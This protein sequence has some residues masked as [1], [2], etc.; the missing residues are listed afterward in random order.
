MLCDACVMMCHAWFLLRSLYDESRHMLLVCNSFFD[1]VAVWCDHINHKACICLL[2]QLSGYAVCLF[3]FVVVLCFSSLFCL[4]DSLHCCCLD[5]I[6]YFFLHPCVFLYTWPPG[7]CIWCVHVFICCFFPRWPLVPR[8]M[9]NFLHCRLQCFQPSS[10]PVH[11][12]LCWPVLSFL[13]LKTIVN[14]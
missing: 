1:P 14:F 10:Q 12:V 8:A 3:S 13:Y 6:I 7:R 5:L 2:F 11:F 4:V 9:N